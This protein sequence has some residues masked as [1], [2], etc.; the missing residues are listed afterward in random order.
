MY[1]QIIFKNNFC[2][3]GHKVVGFFKKYVVINITKIKDKICEFDKPGDH[4][5]STKLLQ[6]MT[7]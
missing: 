3:K 5:S 7:A 4:F 2:K 6:W 1:N